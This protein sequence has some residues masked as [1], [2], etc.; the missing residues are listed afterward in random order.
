MRNIIKIIL[1]TIILAM[2]FINTSFATE[3]GEENSGG[4]VVAIYNEKEYVA[5]GVTQEALM[6]GQ[7]LDWSKW[8]S[9]D[10]ITVYNRCARN[11]LKYYDM[12][13]GKK[14]TWYVNFQR[15]CQKRIKNEEI[16]VIGENSATLS[17][18]GDGSGFD[19][20]GNPVY[21]AKYELKVAKDMNEDD[22]EKAEEQKKKT[23][24]EIAE[25]KNKTVKEIVQYLKEHNYDYPY[26]SVGS[27]WEQKLRQS[28]D[29]LKK[30]EDPKFDEY[31]KVYEE[32]WGNYETRTGAGSQQANPDED[33]GPPAPGP[34][35]VDDVIKGAQ[36]F[37]AEGSERPI[38]ENELKSASDFLFNIFL[39]IA[40]IVAVIIG[41]IIGIQFMVASVEEKAKVKEALVP[42]AVGCTVVFGAFGIWKLVVTILSSI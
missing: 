26:G 19:E 25:Y 12:L 18:A 10:I 28:L 8:S 37:L 22:K 2:F 38:L 32:V 9:V 17:T 34:S 14:D 42:Y 1:T 4:T 16:V 40:M 33:D 31:K 29:S 6:N 5:I 41:T 3:L 13:G 24:K 39:G 23:E 15:E 21:D 27:I 36:D 20:D 11:S 7:V 30:S 35:T